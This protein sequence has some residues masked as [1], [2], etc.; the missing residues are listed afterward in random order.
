[1]KLLLLGKHGQVGWEL[2]RSLSLVGEVVALGSGDPELCG[3]LGNPDGLQETIERVAPDVIINAGA[4]TAVDRA[5][6]ESSLAFL[7][8]ASGP[9]TLATMAARRNALLVHFSSDYVFSGTGTRPWVE[10]DPFDPCNTYGITKAEGDRRIAQSGARHLIFR[11]SWVYAPRGNNFLRTILRLA[12]ERRQLEVV[13]D[14]WGAPTGADLI[15]DVTAAAIRT[16]MT[17]PNLSGTF[18]LAPDGETCWHQYAR[19]IVEEASALGMTLTTEPTDVRPIATADYPT[20]AK[21]PENS[22]LDNSRLKAT[23]SVVMPDWQAGVR[24]SV[25]EIVNR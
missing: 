10:T 12:S 18:H 7:V 2:Q 22:R 23:F 4:Y 11:T 5:E 8:N 6:T 25:A 16:A 9:A 19:L 17:D 20:P 1:M 14:Q 15:A 13:S 21:R 3:D 24:R